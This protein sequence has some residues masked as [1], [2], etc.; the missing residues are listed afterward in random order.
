M[1]PYYTRAAIN[2]HS[3]YIDFSA[4][5]VYNRFSVLNVDNEVGFNLIN[6]DFNMNYNNLSDSSSNFNIGSDGI[7]VL[8]DNANVFNNNSVSSFN[9]DEE[10]RFKLTNDNW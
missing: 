6:N 10:M 8:K 7:Y 2:N 4:T 3:N 9:S 5:V 1:P